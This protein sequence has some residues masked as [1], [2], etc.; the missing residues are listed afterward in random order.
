M[1]KVIGVECW[2]DKFFF[3]RLLSDK[4]VIRKEKNKNEVL[5]SIIE[6]SKGNFS[7]GIVD[8]DDKE[9]EF[10]LKDA[11]VERKVEIGDFI[12]V[13]KLKN[14]SH[15][16]VQLKPKEFEKWI[17][18]FVKDLGKTI[19][20]FGYENIQDFMA[21]SKSLPEKLLRTDR[22]LKIMNFVFQHLEDSE[23]HILKAKRILKYLV[24]KKYQAD[25]NELINV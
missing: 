10:Y 3:E 14:A 19:G 9:I 21:E 11:V 5:K 2:A 24:E 23:N 13:I 22:F 7:I 25:I 16:I 1:E 8:E 15:F 17:E 18:V 4:K 12:E 6:R 20:D